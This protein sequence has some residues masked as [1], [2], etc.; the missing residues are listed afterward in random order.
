M[1][2]RSASPDIIGCPHQEGID[3]YS[4]PY[5]GIIE[6]AISQ[7]KSRHERVTVEA[8]DGS[9]A[10]AYLHRDG[11]AWGVNGPQGVN[12]LRGIRTPAGADIAV[13]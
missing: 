12:V 8:Q 13:S 9:E 10:Y 6:A 4:D 5:S 3:Y 1:P 2:I 7:A 11:I